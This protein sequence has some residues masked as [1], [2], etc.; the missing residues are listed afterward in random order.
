[1]SRDPHPLQTSSTSMASSPFDKEANARG[2]SQ[3]QNQKHPWS[4]EREG[5]GIL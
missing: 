3:P 5:Q 2:S 4:G 1:L